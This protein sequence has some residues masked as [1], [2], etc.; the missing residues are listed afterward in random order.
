MPSW[1]DITS[2]DD[3]SGGEDEQGLL[4]SSNAIQRLVSQEVDGESQGLDG[5]GLPSERVVVGGFSQVSFALQCPG[6][7][8][9]AFQADHRHP[10][11]LPRAE[12]SRFLQR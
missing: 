10:A 11:H 4:R 7:T 5:K 9:G 1:F 8:L 3:V 6:Q 12:R 2:L